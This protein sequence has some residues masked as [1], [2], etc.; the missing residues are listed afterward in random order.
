M[1]LAANL[2]GPDVFLR[3]DEIKEL[4]N[5]PDIDI[6]KMQQTYMNMRSIVAKRGVAENSFHA[7][8]GMKS[9]GT[10]GSRDFLEAILEELGIL[11]Q[12]IIFFASDNG[13]ESMYYSE[14]GRCSGSKV[15][16]DGRKIEYDLPDCERC[17]QYIH[18]R[19]VNALGKTYHFGRICF[20]ML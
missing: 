19:V 17:K 1:A 8:V 16:P 14:A 4:Q 13:H 2:Y 10:A 12:T 20:I 11:D 5:H 7:L 18:G 15:T 3:I 6:K 9:A